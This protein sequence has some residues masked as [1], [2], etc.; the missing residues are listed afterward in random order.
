MARWEIEVPPVNDDGQRLGVQWFN[1]DAA[2]YTVARD[3]A[4][5]DVHTED[6]IRHR[7]GAA[8]DVT[9]LKVRAW[10]PGSI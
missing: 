5:I 1:F 3:Q 7:R 6:A 10:W 9:G 2:D 4:L 8:V